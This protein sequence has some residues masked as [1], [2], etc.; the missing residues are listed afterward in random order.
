M[1]LNALLQLPR[2]Y[3]GLSNRRR[4]VDQLLGVLV[5]FLRTSAAFPLLTLI[6]DTVHGNNDDDDDDDDEGI[7]ARSEEHTSESSHS[8]ESRMP[9]SA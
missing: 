3:T 4:R 9:S 5:V 2:P 1:V 7:L 6:G 8:G